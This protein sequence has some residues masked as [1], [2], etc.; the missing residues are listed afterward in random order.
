VPDHPSTRAL[1]TAVRCAQC[2]AP[3]PVAVLVSRS[4][5]GAPAQLLSLDPRDLT[6]G[7]S[8]DCDISFQQETPGVSRQH[9]TL[10]WTGERFELRDAGST[11]GTS[12]NGRRLR[13][14]EM[15]A[16]QHGDELLLG[17]Q[18]LTY[19]EILPGAETQVGS[20]DPRRE[21]LERGLT[22]LDPAEVV[23]WGLELLRLVS[24][25]E[26]SLLIG[27]G[28]DSRLEPLLVPLSHPDL[29][30]SRS[31][32]AQAL[33]SGRTVSR[34]L[35]SEGSELTESIA[36]LHLRRIWVHP[37][38]GPD[39]RP[40]AAV[41]LD[42]PN[43]GAPFAPAVE[44]ELVSVAEHIGVALRNALLHVEVLDLN[45]TLE[46]RVA[47]RT[48]ELEQSRAQI[49]A[50]DRLVTLGR[51]VAAI[52]HEMNNPVG[53]IASFAG[54]LRGL[55]TPLLETRAELAAALPEPGALARAQALLDR[56]L[57]AS[58]RPPIDTRARRAQEEALAAHL[59]TAAV[60]AA[61]L[62]ARRLARIG[63]AAGEVESVLDVLR[64]RGEVVSALAERLFTFGRSLETIGQ[65]SADLA[66]IVDGL[67][68]YSHLDRSTAE[69]AD[70]HRGIEAALSVLAPRIPHGIEVVTHFG[71]IEPFVHRPGEL[72]QVWTNLVDNAVR[73]MGESGTLTIETSDEGDTVRVTVTDSGPGIP[74]ALQDHIFDL[75][76]TTRGPGAG[77]GLGLPICRTIVEQ[78]HHGKI[79]FVSRPGLTSFAV[80]LPKHGPPS[81]EP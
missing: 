66:R 73:A 53:A 72:T 38:A 65:C 39:A 55:A 70:L 28:A 45:R 48:R 58:R 80:V 31:T 56:A 71:E 35:T 24:G 64:Q 59:T 9:A 8:P 52:A 7:R 46:Q 15:V 68:T 43:A 79:A 19:L 13:P 29:K 57:E 51:L 37:V 22:S 6:L 27:A 21:E 33:E 36:L 3:L 78:N 75:H 42:S 5:S 1:T 11:Y 49:V 2:G 63:L 20:A 4:T 14:T 67:K 61:D 62:V 34:S 69:V 81:Q 16:L 77:L 60:P 30:V 26:R 25:V 74:L 50:Q 18:P 23:S 32:I 54:T 12:V 47:D 41:Y 40:L 17:E 44:Q 10:R 76:V